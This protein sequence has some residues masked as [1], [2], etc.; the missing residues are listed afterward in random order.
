M[1]TLDFLG[2]KGLFHTKEGEKGK[3]KCLFEVGP[4]NINTKLKK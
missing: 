2:S 1:E 4:S 3:G